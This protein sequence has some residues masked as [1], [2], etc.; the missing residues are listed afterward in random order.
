MRGSPT[1][2]AAA[3]P[4][5]RLRSITFAPFGAL[6]D[7]TLDL[8][9]PADTLHVIYGPNEA[10]K[11]TAL[12]GLIGFFFGIEHHNRDRHDPRIEPRV[13]A[14]IDA[15]DGRTLDLV[16]RKGRK[17]TL[18]DGA[19]GAPT[20]DV[21]LR[22]WIAGLDEATFRQLH[23]LDH[24]RL[25]EGTEAV[26]RGQGRLGELLLEASTGATGLADRLERLREEAQGL[27][28][29]R[30]KNALKGAVDEWTAAHK[31][32]TQSMLSP[33]SWQEQ[34]RG[35][36]D[37]R[38]RVAEAT[39]ELR[40]ARDEQAHLERLLAVR[41]AMP[42]LRRRREARAALGAIPAVPEG[43]TAL[44][45]LHLREASEA[46]TEADRAEGDALALRAQVQA[47]ELRAAAVPLG[48]DAAQ[49]RE[50]RARI[51][52]ARATRL[53][54][55][56]ELEALERALAAGLSRLGVMPEGSPAWTDLDVDARTL[57]RAQA[58]ATARREAA[59]ARA[60]A[61]RGLAEAAARR[62]RLGG[63]DATSDP[64]A[65]C[66][67]GTHA[68]LDAAVAAGRRA[69][70]AARARDEVAT[71]EL[72]AAARLAAALVAAGARDVSDLARFAAPDA[73]ALAADERMRS[74]DLARI[75]G[76][77][78]E[79][80]AAVD[81][82]A[83][84]A[85]AL[86][87]LRGSSGLPLPEELDAA[88]ARRD[89]ALGDV[90]R[91]LDEGDA[92]RAAPM[93]R[94]LG[95]LVQTTDS[96]A[97]R[98]RREA[99]RVEHAAQLLAEQRAAQGR[100]DELR[101][102]LDAAAREAAAGRAAWEA[103]WPALYGKDGAAARSW[104]S[105]RGEA[106]TLAAELDAVR[107]RREE[108]D[109]EVRGAAIGLRDA[110]S[111]ARAQVGG[112]PPPEV[113]VPDDAAALGAAVAAAEH[114]AE[115]LARRARDR[116]ERAAALALA[117]EAAAAAEREQRRAID[118]EARAAAELAQLVTPL[119]LSGDASAEETTAVLSTL[120][121]ATRDRQR[122]DQVAAIIARL[123][124][125]IGAV[126]AAWSAA[127][128][129]I[130][131]LGIGFEDALARADAARDARAEL[132]R[133]EEAILARQV[134]VTRERARQER[135]A[136][137]LAALAERTGV[138]IDQLGA[139]EARAGHARGL[140]REIEQLEATIVDRLG[141][142]SLEA[143]EDRL[144][145]VD[146]DV[147]AERADRLAEAIQEIESRRDRDQR[148]IGAR[149]QGLALLG[150]DSKA[151][152]LAETAEAH[153]ARARALARRAA[154]ARAAVVLLEREVERHRSQ[155]EGPVLR[156]AGEL[157]RAIT[158]AGWAGLRASEG[159][160]GEPEIRC[161]RVDGKEHP[162]SELSQGTADQLYLSLRLAALE[163]HAQGGARLP[164]ILDD[165][166]VHFDDERVAATLVALA[167]V[168]R[169]VQVL[170]FTHERE[171][172]DAAR[173]LLGARAVVHE[174]SRTPG[175]GL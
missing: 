79:L 5:V 65:G 57:A 110:L 135:A 77:S 128:R 104:C 74:V 7:V 53:D 13:R 141:C 17:D 32:S 10:G 133:L 63:S 165:V 11:S 138:P 116:R 161:V 41:D 3:R 23:A 78:R 101:A 8:A 1:T 45:D 127:T 9:G 49:G 126:E 132:L 99:A 73:D 66:D 72:D 83:R 147:V 152:E 18:L 123:D 96:L 82:A 144:R 111:A 172:A 22:R 159:D 112:Q 168:A 44:R 89:A 109:L 42:R 59:M 64:T 86:D 85:A 34:E 4:E 76:F 114:A 139:A 113:R 163:H 91:A 26:V 131:L 143:A 14:V 169:S 102:R 84:A 160:D 105:R 58:R 31:A 21:D 124:H 46:A 47:C 117:D 6:R 50:L 146:F 87:A 158:E 25:R 15:G 173:E 71:R 148:D 93:V 162:V 80:E 67:P 37:T 171:V 140:D 142:A 30:G 166:L 36:E 60:V 155:R 97:D 92:R 167:D 33:T 149:E 2:K 125:E 12:R 48:F 95:D 88:R 20:S 68:A 106:I 121:E 118:D 174:L 75:E 19:T 129:E 136:A 156:R 153:L 69:L 81:Q 62:A 27:Y 145:G 94:A 119:G 107:R 55:A 130:G 103:R 151:A 61:E 137:S 54:A 115:D 16:R 38:R 150:G 56:A 175:S 164:L 108:L 39:E 134:V 35:I 100:A 170:L 43:A 51:D 120:A 154:V 24:V 70:I 98:L 157:F 52:R 122:R 40:R 29:V 28:R 90:A